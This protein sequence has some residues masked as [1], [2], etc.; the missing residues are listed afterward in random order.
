MELPFLAQGQVEEESEEGF[1][2]SNWQLLQ[3]LE[4]GG[5][6]LFETCSL[7]KPELLLQAQLGS[8]MQAKNIAF[9]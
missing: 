4:V 7:G 5:K 3:V 8:E 1:G 6:D 2:N 9:S